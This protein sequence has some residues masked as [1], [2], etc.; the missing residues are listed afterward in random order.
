MSMSVTRTLTATHG[1]TRLLLLVAGGLVVA[2][3]LITQYYWPQSAFLDVT[4]HPIG[5]DFI[6]V[7]GGPQIAFGHGLETLFDPK[8]YYAAL[9][10]VYGV[11]IAYHNWGYPLFVLPLYW[12]FAQMPYLAALAVWTLGFLG[13]Y[14]WIVT[15]TVEPGKRLLVAG[16]LVVAPSSIIN[17]IGGQNGFLTATLWLGGILWL[18]RRPIL[19][20]ILIGLLIYKPHMG[21]CLPFV[22]IALGAWRAFLAAAITSILVFASSLFLVDV[23]DWMTYFEVIAPY[24]ANLLVD[25]KGFYTYMMVSVAAGGRSAGLSFE[26]AFA[27]QAIVSLTVLVTTIATVRR[28]TDRCARAFVIVAA[29]PLITPYAFNYDLAALTAVVVWNLIGRLKTTNEQAAPIIH[30][31]VW[32]IPLVTMYPIP[33]HAALAPITLLIAFAYIV[34][35]IWSPF[36]GEALARPI[37]NNAVS[38]GAS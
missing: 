11:D 9:K 10:Q 6:N 28:T 26:T 23:S 27:I 30:V 35:S 12:L 2:A 15:R 38:E 32:M 1:L 24:Q 29:T 14:I 16:L 19:A 33:H 4:K 18:D 13:T 31:L 37:P 34:H 25:F 22:L 21:L 5:R 7:W 36:G 8:A 17:I 3:P 20:G